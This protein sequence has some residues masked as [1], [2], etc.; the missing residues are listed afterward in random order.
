MGLTVQALPKELADQ[1]GVGAGLA[2]I[3]TAVEQDSPADQNGIQPGDIIT[4]VNRQPVTSPRQFRQALKA[5]NTKK[6]I[7]INVIS[8]GSTRMIILKESND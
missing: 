2:V 8:N 7:L 4:T 5:A 6:G 3:V 1:D